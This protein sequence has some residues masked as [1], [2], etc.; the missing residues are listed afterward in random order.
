MFQDSK[1]TLSFSMAP[2]NGP[3]CPLFFLLLQHGKAVY[4]FLPGKLCKHICCSLHSSFLL[5]IAKRRWWIDSNIFIALCSYFTLG[6]VTNLFYRNS[7]STRTIAWNVRPHTAA[8]VI[9]LEPT[10]MFE[11][12]TS[13]KLHFMWN[14]FK[15]AMM[16]KATLL[17][18]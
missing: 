9:H 6:V 4:L 18:W 14:L 1:C 7:V 17:V 2:L 5:C 13:Y 15:C 11:L 12:H 3:F 10:F 8:Q 16:V